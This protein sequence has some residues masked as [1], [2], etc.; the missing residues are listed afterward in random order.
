MSDRSS[1]TGR[2]VF[3]IGHS[4]HPAETFLDLLRQYGIEVIADVRSQPYSRYASQFNAD[5]LKETLRAAGLQYVPLG[6]EL[7]GR[8]DE[9]EFYDA[10]GYVL[11]AR[12]ARSPLFLQG[13]DRV[14]R[15]LRDFC[16]ALMCSEEDP[17]GCHRY[18]LVARVLAERG[19]AV[20]HI[21]GDGRVHDSAE[22][23]SEAD[24]QERRQGLLFKE[25]EEDSWRSIRSVSRKNP[26]RSSSES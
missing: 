23:E 9:D 26:Q 12:L 4:N 10:E 5:N 3:T 19:I 21:R 8:P 1:E 2:V 14:E 13:I 6:A 16:I 11:Y 20:R 7:G 22:L 25:T 17:G 24:R 18:R 15:G